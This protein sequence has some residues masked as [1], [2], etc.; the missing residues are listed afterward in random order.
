MQNHP[1]RDGSL[2]PTDSG[3]GDR[4]GVG[5]VF[6]SLMEERYRMLKGGVANKGTWKLSRSLTFAA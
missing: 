2:E 4:Q 5:R 3:T 6:L 1:K